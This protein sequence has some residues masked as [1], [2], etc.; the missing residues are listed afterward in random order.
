[1]AHKHSCLALSAMRG[2]RLAACRAAA[3]PM[4]R[5][6]RWPPRRKPADARYCLRM[7][8]ITGTR[9]ETIRC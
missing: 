6:R 5:T 1:M 8:P 4:Q 2:G 3:A 7:E 9:I